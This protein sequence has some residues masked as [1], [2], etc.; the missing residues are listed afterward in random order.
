MHSHSLHRPG[1]AAVS[2]AALAMCVATAA[3]TISGS[4]SDYV[5]L[6]ALARVLTVAAPIAVGL[7][8]LTLPPFARFGRLLILGGVGWFLASLSNSDQATLYS[9][10]RIF[11]WAVEVMIIYLLLAFP[12]G[13]LEGRVDRALVWAGVVLLLIL[14]LPTALLVELYPVPVQWTACESGCPENALMVTGSEPGFIEDVVRPLREILTI[15]LFAAVALRLA[16]RIRDAPRLRRRT[17]A[18]V[19]AVASF[20]CA[21]F[22]GILLGRRVAPE[23]EVVEVSVWLLASTVPLTAIAFL[24][25]LGR[26]WLFIAGSTQRLAARLRGHPSP[27]ELRTALAEVFED[28]SLEIVYWLDDGENGWA[29][30]GGRPVEQPSVASGRCLT[31]VLDGTDRVAGIIHDAALGDDR[32]FIDTATSFALMTLDNHRLSAQT[33]SLLREVRESRARIQAAADEERRRI[34]RDLHDGAQQRLVAL[35]IKL[36]LAAE[37]TGGGEGDGAAALR[38]L[39]GD[40]EEAL[41]EIRSLARGIYPS[42]LADRGLVEGLRAAALRNPLPTTVLAAGVQRYSREIES[43]AYFC[44]LEALQ[45]AAKHAQGASAAVIDL[46]DN[47]SLRLEVRDDGAGFDPGE[48]AAGVGFTN[49]RDRLAAVGG[50][51]GITS[52]P[53]RGTR[54]TARIPIGADVAVNRSTG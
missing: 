53:G 18:P 3:V 38:G 25:G 36:E 42:P 48:V 24:L 37:R 23:S 9:I 52:S 40:V 50:E 31:E 1:P 26:W 12:T 11:G 15:A 45:N 2:V 27:E 49:M 28:P 34:E 19:L 8:A 32:A 6:E 7:Y 21:A 54:V 47:G 13:R 17:F 30:A 4:T 44:C 51:L 22:G 33:S 16:A 46:Y 5:E 41:D 14:Y 35:R 10:G 43:A 29:D 20:R 39:G